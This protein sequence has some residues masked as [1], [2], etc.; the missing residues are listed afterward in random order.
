MV[1]TVTVLVGLSILAVC[2]RVAARYKR[3]V[4]FDID[5]YLCFLSAILL[6]AM[7][8]ELILCKLGVVTPLIEP[9]V[10]LTSI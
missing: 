8:V 3:R 7:L 9:Q 5:D 10:S 6:L 2:F 1:A 4:R